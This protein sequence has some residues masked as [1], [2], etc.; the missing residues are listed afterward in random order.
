MWPRWATKARTKAGS[1][2]RERQS[3]DESGVGNQRAPA[4]ADGSTSDCGPAIGQS[5]QDFDQEIIGNLVINKF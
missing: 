2:I 3:S 4:L 5:D 1:E